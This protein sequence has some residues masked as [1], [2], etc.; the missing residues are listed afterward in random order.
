MK[1]RRRILPPTPRASVRIRNG[2]SGP[3]F[4][5]PARRGGRDGLA[6]SPFDVLLLTDI[7]GP[8]YAHSARPIRIETLTL[9]EVKY[10]AV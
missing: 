10:A 2:G 8:L 6:L 9:P 5:S 3:V 4:I 1:Y 7:P